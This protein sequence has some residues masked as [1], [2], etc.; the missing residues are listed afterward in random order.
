ME[1][2]QHKLLTPE[3]EQEVR[4]TLIYQ[5]KIAAIKLYMKYVPC[6]LSEAKKAVEKIGESIEPGPAA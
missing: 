6:R 2:R 1:K 4:E 5:G 3:A